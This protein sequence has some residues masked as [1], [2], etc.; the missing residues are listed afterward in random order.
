MSW[1][2]QEKMTKN[3]ALEIEKL[4]T[5]DTSKSNNAVDYTLA[6]PSQ[7]IAA[8]VLNLIILAVV[9]FFSFW[10]VALIKSMVLNNPHKS[11]SI[12]YS[13]LLLTTLVYL[14]IQIIQITKTGQSLGK[15]IMR[16][17]VIK[18]NGKEPSIINYFLLRELCCFCLVIFF[19]VFIFIVSILFDI[20]LSLKSTILIVGFIFFS[21]SLIMLFLKN[22]KQRTMQDLIARTI[23]IQT[24]K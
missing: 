13:F 8:V 7:R 12:V 14:C 16:I 23:V 5:L 10:L 21:S 20:D 2:R 11:R 17:K 1:L 19:P 24:P 4:H 6:T 15:K 9:A 22:S 3:F 18:P